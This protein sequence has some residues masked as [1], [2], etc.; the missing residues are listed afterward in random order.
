[1]L[2]EVINDEAVI[3]SVFKAAGY[4]YG[5]LLGLYTFGLFLN[6]KVRDA[7]VPFVCLLSPAAAYLLNTYSA[8]LFNGY[9]FGFEILIVNG[10]I[11]FLGLMAIKKGRSRRE[12]DQAVR[13]KTN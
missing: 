7:L 8:E 13:I 4:T 10:F 11:T 6:W 1:M 5:P 12:S 9:Q 3:S 2:F